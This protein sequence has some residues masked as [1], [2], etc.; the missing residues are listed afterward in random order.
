[1]LNSHI[2]AL[3]LHTIPVKKNSKLFHNLMIRLLFSGCSIFPLCL[4]V[5]RF[6]FLGVILQQQ[7]FYGSKIAPFLL[8]Y[9]TRKF[10]FW[11][12]RRTKKEEEPNS[13]KARVL[14]SNLNFQILNDRL[15][16]A[17]N[18]QGIWL[19][20]LRSS[21]AKDLNPTSL[22]FRCFVALIPKICFFKSF[23]A[24]LVCICGRQ[25]NE[26][27]LQVFYPLSRAQFH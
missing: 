21:L 17:S 4:S 9:L 16:S 1:M 6:H 25:L 15:K 13:F 23:L 20:I 24:T 27:I 18:S 10:S 2:K 3:I 22:L 8:N 5:N 19:I 14:E 11:V 7:H 12:L 26:H